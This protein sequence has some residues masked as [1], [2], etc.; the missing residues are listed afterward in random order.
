MIIHLAYMEYFQNASDYRTLQHQRV[1]AD[2]ANN[3]SKD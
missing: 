3:F 1:K 2:C